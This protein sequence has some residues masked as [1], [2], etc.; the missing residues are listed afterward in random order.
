MHKAKHFDFNI[1]LCHII[2]SS[3]SNSVQLH[4]ILKIGDLRKQKPT[5]LS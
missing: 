3:S 1:Y 4:Q 2:V 5:M